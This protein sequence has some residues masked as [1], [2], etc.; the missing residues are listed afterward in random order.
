[1]SGSLTAGTI[2]RHEQRAKRL[3]ASI[4]AVDKGLQIALSLEY[5]QAFWRAVAM[6]VGM[7][8]AAV[9]IVLCSFLFQ[10]WNGMGLWYGV[11][12]LAVSA[13]AIRPALE[14]VE[15]HHIELQ[16]RLLELV[17]KRQELHEELASLYERHEREVARSPRRPIEVKEEAA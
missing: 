14:S 3:N 9:G 17:M 2:E 11:A 10:F 5:R 6:L 1:M 8:T 13:C 4:E 12:C 16:K 7:P 15:T